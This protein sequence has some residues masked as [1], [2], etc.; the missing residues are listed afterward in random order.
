MH[1]RK[2]ISPRLYSLASWVN[3]S[4]AFVSAV[5]AFIVF[6]DPPNQEFF[7]SRPLLT[8]VVEVVHGYIFVL[9]FFYLV[10]Y[11]I[12]WFIVK[13]VDPKLW[14]EVQFIL[15]KYQEKCFGDDVERDHHRV[16]LFQLKK[17]CVFIKHWSSKRWF[18][19]YGKPGILENF[20]VPV[21]RS[22]HL[23]KKSNACFHV[24]DDG[25]KCEGIAGAAYR[26]RN[27]IVCNDLPELARKG[28]SNKAK[29]QLS[30]DKKVYAESTNCCEEMIDRYLKK[31]KA[32]PR[33]IGATPI[34]V[35]GKIWGVI[36]LDSRSPDAITDE[37]LKDFTIVIGTI[38]KLLERA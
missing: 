7:A 25:E 21:L 1:L 11:L 29:K 18:W 15:D 4:G 36:V 26:S 6:L 27:I 23:S 16:T 9:F 20:L 34:D 33:S 17:R 5:F 10:I 35:N 24:P 22:A 13:R 32:V 38:G 2:R 3:S 12:S 28:S 31:E 8:R 19:P 14:N 30:L 37:S